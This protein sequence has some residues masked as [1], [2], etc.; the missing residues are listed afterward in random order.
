MS[1]P[2]TPLSHPM[3]IILTLCL[4]LLL[5]S[6][7]A[8]TAPPAPQASCHRLPHGITVCCRTLPSGKIVC[9]YRYPSG[10]IFCPRTL[11]TTP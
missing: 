4:A 9:C 1:A 5:F 7:P 11:E 3:T 8:Q 6:A 2:T 10:R